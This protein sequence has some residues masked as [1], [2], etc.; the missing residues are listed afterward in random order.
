MKALVVDRYGPPDVLRLQEVPKPR[1]GDGEVLVE[2]RT[3]AIN[4]WDWGLVRGRPY[5]FRLIFGFR[6]PKL[7]ILGVEVA[8]TV[9]AVGEG[10]RR[11]GLGDRVYGD[12]SEA[13]QGGFAEYVCVHENAL[14][15]MPSE[16]TFEQ[17]AAIPHAAG[18]AVQGLID[19][20]RLR[21]GER[22]LIN[23]AGG[24]VGVIGVQVAKR[25]GCEVTGVDS[26]EK[27]DAMTSLGFDH[28]I[29]Y[30]REDF[31]R[32]GRRYDLI[33]DAKSTR[34]PLSLL[35][36]LAPGGRYMTVGGRVPRLIQIAW[37]GRL[38]NKLTDKQIRLV[39]LEPNKSLDY[40]NEMFETTGLET[41]IDGLYP[42]SEVPRA[43]RR[44]GEA[45][46]IGKIVVTLGR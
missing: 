35:R 31:T 33:L 12:I 41:L 17:A 3:T 29:D 2:V 24:G 14:G 1:P 42:L 7:S 44:F 38:I 26:A 16:M 11:F 9:E 18:L 30:R 15:P 39:T 22:V 19:H 32:N 25:L 13:G 10:A 4:D 27:L 46:H 37:L 43:L 8:G 6:R 28:V 36:S 34:S 20:G 40:V 23:G 5:V 45:E 21:D